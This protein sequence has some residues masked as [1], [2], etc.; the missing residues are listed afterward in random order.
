MVQ[1]DP[2]V[3]DGIE[4][5][6]IL[7]GALFC[8]AGLGLAKFAVRFHRAPLETVRKVAALLKGRLGTRPPALIDFSERALG[9][10]V[11]NYATTVVFALMAVALFLMGVYL[12]LDG[13]GLV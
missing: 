12:A 6:L 2:I 3:S 1:V 8:A 9:V 11:L 13:V 7:I 4:P 10:P 5:M